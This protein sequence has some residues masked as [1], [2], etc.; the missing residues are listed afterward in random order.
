MS[1]HPWPHLA[2]RLKKGQVLLGL[3][4]GAKTIGVAVSDPGLRVATPMTTLRRGGKVSLD[5]REL[6]RL[7]G[8]REAGGFVIGLPL[9]E[10]GTEGGAAGKIRLFAKQMLEAKD[11]FGQEP[12]ISFFDERFSTA[13]MESFLIE[14]ADVRREKRKQVIDKLAAQVILQAALDRLNGGEK[15]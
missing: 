9:L 12:Q 4:V 6:A 5:L 13:A 3:D 11:V 1:I 10:N 7:A 15:K 8:E 14:E 2:G